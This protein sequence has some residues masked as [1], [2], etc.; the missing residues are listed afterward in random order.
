[1]RLST[2]IFRPSRNHKKPDSGYSCTYHP[3]NPFFHDAY[4]SWSC[5][6]K[7]TIDFSDFLNTK[8]CAKG[9]HSNVKPKEPE[10]PKPVKDESSKEI[11]Y[12]PP[13][14]K[15][16]ERPS[17]DMPVTRLPVT[18][19]ASLKTALNAKPKVTNV[20]TDGGNELKIGT[21]CKNGGCKTVY[22]GDK[23]NDSPCLYHSGTPIFHEGM[24]YWTCCQRKTSDFTSFLSQEGCETGKHLWNKTE[25]MKL[26]G[27]TCRYDWHQTSSNITVSIY[28][29]LTNPHLSYIEVNPVKISAHIVFGEEKNVFDLQK[30]L[31]GVIDVEKS[32]VNLLGTKVEIILKKA[33]LMSW[34]RLELPNIGSVSL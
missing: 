1:M 30:S 21:L 22:E 13:V 19:G 31:Y 12:T 32:K 26:K 17:E 9:L 15:P 7:K 2:K 6:N 10:K 8:G 24:K 28:A 27:S 3:G 25:E 5:C 16:M 23:S 11:S 18:I 14:Q 4:K 33:E 20:N 29:R 34:G